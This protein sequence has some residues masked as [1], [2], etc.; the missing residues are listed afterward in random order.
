[1]K[2]VSASALL[3]L[4]VVCSTPVQA[5]SLGR[6][7]FTP[8]QRANLDAGKKEKNMQAA[9]VRRGPAIV[10][11]DGVVVRSDGE[12]TV[13]VN[14]KASNR[15]RSG[16]IRAAP[17]ADPA[18]ARV[19]VPG[20]GPRELRVGQ[21]LDTITGT[22]RESFAPPL[23]EPANRSGRTNERTSGPA[24]LVDGPA[25]NAPVAADP[26]LRP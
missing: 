8:A 13:W 5:E 19:N 20:A 7:F 6:L 1:M 2:R 10:K 4:A 14:G 12:T 16:R 22:V 15:G 11:L 3:L 17:A 21:Q 26:T 9:P 25:P 23:R 24:E 18:S